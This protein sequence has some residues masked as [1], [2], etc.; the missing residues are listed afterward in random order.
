MVTVDRKTLAYVIGLAIGD[1]NLSNP[2]GRAPRL[3]ITCDTR[4]ALLIK[5]IQKA[6]QKLLP[7]NRVSLVNRSKGCVDISSYSKQW[8]PWLGWK[9]KSGSKRQQNVSVPEWILQKKEFLVPCLKGLIETDGSIYRD[10]GYR[11]V[12]FVTTIPKLASDVAVMISKLGF[13]ASLSTFLSK[14]KK[15][16]TKYTIRIC[17]NSDELVKVLKLSKA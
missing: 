9:A 17:K 15:H 14:N 7:E 11:M 6:I 8:E 3:R 12:N 16:Q 1:G 4:Y 10:R 5:R 2:N 13:K